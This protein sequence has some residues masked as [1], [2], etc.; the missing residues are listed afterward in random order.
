V[1][2]FEEAGMYYFVFRG[3]TQ[4][5][6]DK[7]SFHLG[8]SD[9]TDTTTYTRE[10]FDQDL[11]TW[12]WTNEL[13]PG[14]IVSYELITTGMH[15]FIIWVREIGTVIDKLIISG[16][17]DLVV[18]APGVSL[19]SATATVDV[20]ATTQLTA[21]IAPENA[22]DKS[23]TWSSSDDAIATVSSSGLVTGVA[24]GTVTI[25]VTTTDGSKTAT[26]DI[27]V[28]PVTSVN[29]I[30]AADF[31]VYPNPVQD[32][33]FIEGEAISTLAIYSVTG[34]AVMKL[35]EVTSKSVNVS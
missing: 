3:N 11:D 4:A 7:N 29:A 24:E 19:D 22:T 1:V 14:E 5:S 32:N 16:E 2:N 31:N 8:V 17:K 28:N 33:L 23:V 34:K 21:T 9:G 10:E 12:Q 27:T 13:K 30:T 18:N 25:T 6:G 20:G 35:E 15:E 26:A